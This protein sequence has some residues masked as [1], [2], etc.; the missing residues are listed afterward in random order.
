MSNSISQL[1]I[2][3][4]GESVGQSVQEEWLSQIR[5]SPAPFGS[6][7]MSKSETGERSLLDEARR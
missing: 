1:H 3:I 7:E 6:S 2:M 5:D 4:N